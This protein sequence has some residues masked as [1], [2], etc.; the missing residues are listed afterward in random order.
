MKEETNGCETTLAGIIGLGLVALGVFLAFSAIR[1]CLPTDSARNARIPSKKE[2]QQ[3]KPEPIHPLKLAKLLVKYEGK[4][5][6]GSIIAFGNEIVQDK[7]GKYIDFVVGKRM[8]NGE[9]RDVLFQAGHYTLDQDKTIILKDAVDE[10]VNEA[11]PV[12]AQARKDTNQPCEFFILGSADALNKTTFTRIRTPDSKFPNETIF[13]APYPPNGEDEVHEQLP[14]TTA[15]SNTIYNA[16][17]V[18]KLLYPNTFD[19]KG[20]A[21]YRGLY[22][23]TF[24]KQI[25]LEYMTSL[26][27][28]TETNRVS[29][30]D[31]KVRIILFIPYEE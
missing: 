17:K 15:T 26:L 4:N 1:S 2:E 24:F 5:I 21:N 14:S 10:L 28:G 19:N 23:K 29:H 13:T 16:Q 20:L 6:H 27:E 9:Y 3:P 11:L 31:R 25:N 7:K 22:A 12:L 18:K 8:G 30:E